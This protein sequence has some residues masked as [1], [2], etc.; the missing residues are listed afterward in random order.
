MIERKVIQDKLRK[1]EY[2]I[3]QLE[4][5]LR[6]AKVYLHALHDILKTVEREESPNISE[7]TLRS[8]SAVA[9]VRE[10]II[11]RGE[12]VH[13]DNLLEALGKGSSREAKASLTS[14]LSAYVRRGEVFSRPAPNTFGLIEL[15]HSNIPEE[16]QE[17]PPEFGQ[18]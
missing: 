16:P 6:S 18:S 4:E 8:G 14:S 7:P 15:G 13:M 11:S 10:V 3:Q 2:E 12:P 9:Q 1:K 5:K 17:P